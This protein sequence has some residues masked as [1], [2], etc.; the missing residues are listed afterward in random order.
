MCRYEARKGNSKP[1]LKG[2]II[3][4]DGVSNYP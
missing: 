4:A 2:E 3:I 1:C